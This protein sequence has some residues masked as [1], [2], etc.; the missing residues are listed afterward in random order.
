MLLTALG[1]KRPRVRGDLGGSLLSSLT[2]LLVRDPFELCDADSLEDFENLTAAES[3][4][5][6]SSLRAD[7]WEAF[8]ETVPAK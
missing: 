1:G 4:S 8:L 7:S 2:L 5:W 3:T 6:S